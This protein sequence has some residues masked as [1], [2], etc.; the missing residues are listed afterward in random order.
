VHDAHLMR[1]GER[2]GDLN[3]RV[4]SL[5]DRQR[6][7]RQALCQRLAVEKLHDEIRHASLIAH[8]VQRTDVWMIEARDAAGFA[9][10]S[11]AKLRVG[12]EHIGQDL[13]GHDPIQPRITRA[14]DFTHPA[15]AN[16][17]DD[18]VWTEASAWSERHGMQ[19]GL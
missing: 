18:I 1:G 12:G 11:I 9:V 8:V 15:R 6:A 17:G 3:R 10:E 16:R 5:V 7:L 13:D 4:K 2:V 19:P 14:I